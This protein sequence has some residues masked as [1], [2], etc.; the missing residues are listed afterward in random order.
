MDATFFGS[1]SKCRLL[2]D[3][4][5]KESIYTEL[6]NSE[7]FSDALRIMDSTPYSVHIQSLSGLYSSYELLEIAANKRMMELV[8]KV[9]E[10]PP[11]NGREAIK[12]YISRWD[13][14]SIKNIITSK[15]LGKELKRSDI[16]VVDRNNYPIGM[17]G[18]LLTAED[19]SLMINENDIDGIAK[20]LLKLGYGIYLMKYIDEYRKERDVSVLLYSL[21]IA[22]YRRF[23]ESVRFFLGN[24]E[25]MRYFIKDEVDMKNLITL[26]K[27]RELNLDFEAVENGLMDLG[28]IPM[29]KLREIYSSGD[30]EEIV[31]KCLS[32]YGVKGVEDRSNISSGESEILMKTE[33]LRRTLPRFSL[34]SNSIGTI[35]N[36]I[37]RFENERN[38]LRIIFAGKAYG[39]QKDKIQRMMVF[40]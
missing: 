6:I 13:I 7:S 33:M 12:S 10:A 30:G 21:D 37:L 26:I 17:I 28:N 11:A 15:F 35:F 2:N 1:A 5:L 9:S 18:N 4:L 29:Q 22:Y 27:A 38:N 3:D 8:L 34:Q 14:D 40:I 31:T 39:M 25:P 24:E 20:Y 23:Y 19:Y 16:F 36:T 32:A